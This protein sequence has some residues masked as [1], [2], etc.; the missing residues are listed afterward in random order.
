M[1]QSLLPVEK[2]AVWVQRLA[3][4]IPD[5]VEVFCMAAID[6][7]SGRYVC[8]GYY[9]S[10]SETLMAWRTKY[11]GCDNADL[12]G[13]VRVPVR[14]KSEDGLKEALKEAKI[15]LDRAV[16]KSSAAGMLR[17]RNKFSE[18]EVYWRS[19]GKQGLVIEHV[20]QDEL[21]EMVRGT[22]RA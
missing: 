20:S 1:T 19:T 2:S 13:S 21:F 18:D 4:V 15:A 3:G 9:E 8:W 14:G 6:R 10:T 7:E 16:W 11:P 17:F 5:Y 12:V 22:G